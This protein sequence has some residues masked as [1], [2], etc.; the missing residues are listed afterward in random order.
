MSILRTVGSPLDDSS[1]GVFE[2]V[3]AK[4]ELNL[5]YFVTESVQDE[6]ELVLS[7]MKKRE[8]GRYPEIFID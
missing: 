1:L 8:E 7:V 6:A 4:L 2:S 5:L 3:A